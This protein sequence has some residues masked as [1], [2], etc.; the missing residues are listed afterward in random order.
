MSFASEARSASFELELE[1]AN[2]K[3]A[4]DAL[5]RQKP[6]WAHT[7]IMTGLRGS[8]AHGTRL[9]KG[10]P[11][12]TDDIDTFGVSV[13]PVDWYLGIRGYHSQAR[14][15][16]DTAGERYDHLIY[17]VRKLFHQLA[18]GNPNVL[19][20]LWLDEVHRGPLT[21]AGSMIMAS[22]SKFLSKHCFNALI[23][24]ATA[25][26]HKM[27]KR[28]Y[29]GYMGKKRKLLVDELGFDVKHAA[30]CV[31]LLQ[32]GIELAKTGRMS[33]R[34][35]E[36]EAKVLR[37]IKAGDW[38][39]RRVVGLCNYLFDAFRGVEG[40]SD[41]PDDV[42]QGVINALLVDVIHVANGEQPDV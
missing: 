1:R 10:H 21:E 30:H 32:M 4:V 24:Y 18:K 12:A 2:T 15:H 14:Q 17:D 31:R 3:L 35:P 40:G 39:Y 19:G 20:W 8:D 37:A 6:D 42:D 25:Q 41:L 33:V 27:D 11:R 7:I 28:R 23:G 34:R 29:H 38:K 5:H 9:T 13:Q 26:M 16:W 36:E 22:R